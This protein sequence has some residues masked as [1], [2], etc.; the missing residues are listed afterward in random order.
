MTTQTKRELK[1]TQE[2][3]CSCVKV[4][5]KAKNGSW[6]GFVHPYNITTEGNNKEK[7]LKALDEMADIYIEGLKKYNYPEHLSV[8]HLTD[9]EDNQKFNQIALLAINQGK[10][11]GPDIYAETKA[12]CS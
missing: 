5:Y 4:A 6:R 2:V 9:E 11:E 1:Y 12:I 3:D 7:I 8:V 10:I